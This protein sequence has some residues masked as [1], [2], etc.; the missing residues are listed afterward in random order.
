MLNNKFHFELKKELLKF[1]IFFFFQVQKKKNDSY[2]LFLKFIIFI[3][4]KNK[5]KILNYNRYKLLT[6][7]QKIKKTSENV[8][9]E[10]LEANI[11]IYIYIHNN[12][13]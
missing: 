11:Y 12:Y 8:Y 6:F 2:Y 1:R 13:K 5:K 3:F 9:R 4:L 7:I 10:Y